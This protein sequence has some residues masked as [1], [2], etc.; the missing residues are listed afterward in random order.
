[1]AKVANLLKCNQTD[2]GM[3]LDQ[4]CT[5]QITTISEFSPVT[6]AI[7]DE[8]IA[9]ENDPGNVTT[10]KDDHNEHEDHGEVDLFLDAR[11]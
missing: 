8:I 5:C 4:G 1:M 10:E 11:S 9:V 2:R 6:V 7:D 3:D